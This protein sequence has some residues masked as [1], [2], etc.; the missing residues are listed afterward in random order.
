MKTRQSTAFDRA[1]GTTIR[2]L[3]QQR[4]FTQIQLAGQL[5]VSFQMVQKYEKG[6]SRISAARLLVLAQVLNVTLSRLTRQL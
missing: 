6:H 5:G 1:L 3:R 2:Q 4:G